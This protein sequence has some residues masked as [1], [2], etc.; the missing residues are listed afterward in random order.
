MTFL[1]M[2]GSIGSVAS[3]SGLSAKDLITFVSDSDKKL[4]N[5][6]FTLLEGKR[7]LV[8]PFDAEVSQAVI[9]SL[10]SIK[11]D[12][13]K[14]RVNL[15][16]KYAQYLVLDLVHTLSKE[17]IFLY[18]YQDSNNEVLFHQVLQI[19]RVKFARVLS[20]LCATYKTDLSLQ[21]SDLAKLVLEHAYMGKVKIT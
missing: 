15:N 17:S 3:I 20:I 1:E 11:D 2:I 12:T 4:L 9:K 8:T 7:V 10:E 21:Q 18:K 19:V 16:S 14:L 6:Y 13:E 5:D